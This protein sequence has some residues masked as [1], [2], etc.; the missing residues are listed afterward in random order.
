MDVLVTGGAGFIGSNLL[1]RLLRESAVRRI[2]CVDLLTGAGRLENIQPLLGD[3]RLQLLQVDLKDGSAIQRLISEERPPH[4][5]HLAAETHVDRSIDAPKSFVETNV[6]GTLNLLTACRT[7]W[8]PKEGKFLHVSTDEVY[9]A[10]GFTGKFTE[11]SPYLPNSPYSASK[12]GA[13]CLVRAWHHTFGFPTLIVHPSNNYGPYQH[14]EKLIPKVVRCALERSPIPIYGEG[15]NVRD[16][17]FVEDTCSAIWETLIRGRVGERY[18]VGANEEVSNITLVKE[19]CRIFDAVAP[20]Y[21]GNS[22]KLIAYVSDR[23]GH[24]FRYALD[25][26]KIAR[27]IGWKPTVKLGEGLRKTIQWCLEHKEWLLSAR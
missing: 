4:V 9:G 23:P 10:L 6:L 16:W 19:I 21:G 17:I 26:K 13:D 24:D 5:V 18:N 25:T 7:C 14:P 20:E 22:E 27:E 2:I 8:G 3:S 12:A 11:E 1:R 15:Q